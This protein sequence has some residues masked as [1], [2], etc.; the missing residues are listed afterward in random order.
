MIDDD[1]IMVK[2]FGLFPPRVTGTMA[3]VRVDGA[4]I[5]LTFAGAPIAAPKSIAR[6]YVYLRGGKSQFGHFCMTDTDVLVLDQNPNTLFGFSLARYA[7]LIP[8]SNIEVH[9]TKSVRVV[10]PDV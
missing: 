3:A 1:R 10:M 5:H 7:E 8:R 2:P 9:D 4:G 6:N